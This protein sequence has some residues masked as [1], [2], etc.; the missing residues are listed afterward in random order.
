MLAPVGP[1]APAVLG[2]LGQ[3]EFGGKPAFGKVGSDSLSRLLGWHL[4][5]E[6][7]QHGGAGSAESGAE[8]AGISSEFLERGKQ[9]AEWRA[10]R[11]VDAVFESRRKQIS[12]VLRER[13]QEQHRILN[14]GDGVR[15]RV[16][17]GQHAAGLLGR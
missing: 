4:R 8:D 2:D 12:A 3:D 11:L 5:I 10:V 16:L 9:W 17:K 15:P 13:S 1:I 7:H 14:V 6:E